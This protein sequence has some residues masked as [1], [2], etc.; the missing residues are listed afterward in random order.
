MTLSA[1]GALLNSAL[2]LVCTF[3]A[4]L[5]TGHP[6]AWKLSLAAMGVTFFV[7]VLTAKPKAALCAVYLSWVLG[8]AAGLALLF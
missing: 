8:A 3:T 5:A 4:G 1:V 2:Y 7:Y 6:M